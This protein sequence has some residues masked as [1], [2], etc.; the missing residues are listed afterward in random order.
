MRQTIILPILVICFGVIMRLLPHIPNVAPL[1]A[2]AL[3]GGMYLD[4]KYALLIPLSIMILSDCFLGFHN[5]ILFVYLSFVFSGVLGLLARNH[6][7]AGRILVMTLLASLQFFIITNFG[8][9]LVSGMYERS[10][11]GLLEAY[12]LAL[13]FFRNT[14][15]G[16]L[17]YT[18]TFILL[19]GFMKYLLQRR[20]PLL[21]KRKN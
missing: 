14:M 13:P 8:V 21:L 11:Q 16:D 5:T 10:L 2:L 1:T 9:W 4:K 3:F 6:K 19:F 18:T 15:F 20:E 7:T 17:L 12:F